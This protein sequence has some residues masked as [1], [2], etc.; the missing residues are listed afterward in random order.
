[1]IH[2]RSEVSDTQRGQATPIDIENIDEVL[3]SAFPREADLP[4]VDREQV[5]RVASRSDAETR[6]GKRMGR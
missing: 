5:G 1:M 6:G 4:G 2:I 3:P